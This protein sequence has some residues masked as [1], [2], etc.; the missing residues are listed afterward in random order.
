[1][2]SALKLDLRPYLSLA[3][4]SFLAIL[5]VMPLNAHAAS[6]DD[7]EL[8]VTGWI[9]YWRAEEGARD[10]RRHID[11]LDTIYPFAFTIKQDGTLSDQAHLSKSYWKS[12]FRAAKREDVDVIPTIMNADGAFMH[13]LLS[14]KK[15]RTKHIDAI[16]SMVKKGKY[17]GVG[18]DYESRKPETIDYFSTFLKE[19]KKKLGNKQLVCTV[20]A[21][22][23][24]DSL[25]KVIPNP[26]RYTYDYD[27][28]GDVCD[29]ID[30]MAYDQ[31][32]ADLKLNESK[33]GQPY[34]PI[35]DVDWVRKVVDLAVDE[36]PNDKL[37]L[38][39]A[40]YGYNYRINTLPNWYRDYGRIG[41][42]NI[43]DIEDLVDEY[44]V[45]PSRNRAGELVITYIHKDSPKIPKSIKAPKG[46]PSGLVTAARALEYANTTG[47]EVIFRYVSWS[48]AEA[49]KQ[50]IDLAKEFKLKGVAIFKIDG[51]E[52]RK[53]WDYLE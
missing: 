43:P 18:I 32:R 42:L 40:T 45:T 16:V 48:D 53:I 26:I 22:T 50:K 15:K 14:D 23:P 49:I 24:P 37:Y 7:H 29:R 52:D 1:M 3:V 46:T 34:M 13:E 41:A 17:D 36:L 10:A 5:F 27:V 20:E 11:Q 47:R 8:A 28:I 44:N 51:D 25:Y 6:N 33:A 30:I 4:L 35:A 39:V 12:L 31:Q 21:R 38:G 9:P 19:L 2:T